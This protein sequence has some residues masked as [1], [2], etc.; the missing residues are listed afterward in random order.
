VILSSHGAEGLAGLRSVEGERWSEDY[1]AFYLESVANQLIGLPF[2][3]GEV[4]W[5][6]MDFRVDRWNPGQGLYASTHSFKVRPGEYNHKG[7][8]DRHRQPK[9]AFYKVRDLYARWKRLYPAR[10]P[11]RGGAR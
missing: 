5:H 7:I 11:R 4:I 6:F 3:S 8:V 9:S 1:Q 2:V 10:P